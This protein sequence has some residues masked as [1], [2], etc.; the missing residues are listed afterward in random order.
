MTDLTKLREAA[1]KVSERTWTPDRTGGFI[2]A[3]D[4]KGAFPIAEVRGWGHYTGK[5]VGALGLDFQ[6]AMTK[7]SAVRDFIALAN[8]ATILSLID[9]CEKLTEALTGLVEAVI[10][11]VNEKGGGGYILARLSDARSA[12]SHKESEATQQEQ[13]R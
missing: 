2:W 13:E 10:A 7:Q 11:E 5:G 9:R 1:E 3:R 8:P 4:H 12:L 6:D